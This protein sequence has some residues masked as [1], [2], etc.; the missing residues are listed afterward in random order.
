MDGAGHIWR[1]VRA[2]DRARSGR[3]CKPPGVPKRWQRIPATKRNCVT[4]NEAT[5]DENAAGEIPGGV[6][7]V[8][9]LLL[10][11]NRISAFPILALAGN[12]RQSHPLIS[13]P[14]MKPCTECACQPVASMRSFRLTPVSRFI[15]SVT[16]AVLLPSRIPIT[17]RSADGGFCDSGAFLFA[18]T[19]AGAAWGVF[20]VTSGCNSGAVIGHLNFRLGPTC[21][22]SAWSF[23]TLYL[24]QFFSLSR[25]AFELPGFP[26]SHSIRRGPNSSA[27][28]QIPVVTSEFFALFGAT[29]SEIQYHGWRE[30]QAIIVFPCQYAHTRFR[31]CDPNV[32][33]P[34]DA[35]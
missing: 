27:R 35:V 6:G 28:S 19:A 16:V 9:R 14:E 2:P 23:R 29:C 20:S 7:T 13:V 26:G 18:G 11:G 8:V 12:H 10:R 32:E 34:A 4:H 25:R 17:F 33:L 1:H 22:R 5:H 31:V 24:H 3:L 15:R 21:L 30:S